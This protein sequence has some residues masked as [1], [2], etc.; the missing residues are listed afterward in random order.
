MKKLLLSGAILLLGAGV[1]AQTLSL[2]GAPTVTF[3]DGLNNYTYLFN[4]TGPAGTAITDVFLSS[5]DLS[6]LNLSIKKN[7]SA[8]TAWSLLSN[9]TPYNYLDFNS[10]DANGNALDSLQSGDQLEVSFSDSAAKFVP[11][12]NHFASAYDATSGNYS[13][14]VTGLVGPSAVPEPGVASLLAGILV[15]GSGLLLRRKK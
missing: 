13:P 6:P 4:V 1:N 7:N 11:S 10:L 15:A 5:D 2:A 12:T 9:D 8:T 14:N 3:A